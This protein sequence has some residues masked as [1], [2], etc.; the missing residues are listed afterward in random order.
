[1]GLKNGK[2]T[3]K[4]LGWLVEEREQVESF[5]VQCEQDSEPDWAPEE[6]K[7]ARR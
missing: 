2:T 3:E 4:V 5:F 1:M 6:G 7:L